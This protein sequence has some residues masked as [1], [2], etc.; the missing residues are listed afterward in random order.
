MAATPRTRNPNVRFGSKADVR[1]APEGTSA[2]VISFAA[3][4]VRD[5]RVAV[6][7]LLRRNLADS[8]LSASELAE[9]KAD[10]R[11][12]KSA[13]SGSDSLRTSARSAAFGPMRLVLLCHVM[14]TQDGGLQTVESP[15]LHVMAQ[16]APG[17]R[18]ADLPSGAQSVMCARTSIIPAAYDDQILRRGLPLYIAAT[19]SPARLGA[20]EI[21]Q[22][23]FR[24]RMLKG[25]LNPNEDAAIQA[26]LREYQRR[27]SH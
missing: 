14:V 24:F 22:G 2:S 3:T 17:G 7:R 11:P 20:L 9:R 6:G 25:T 26:R 12:I 13:M 19:G 16:T 23:Q 21:S 10:V 18:L 5:W 15:N 8:R 1:L 27:F 4:I